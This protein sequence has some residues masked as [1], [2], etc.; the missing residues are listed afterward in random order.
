[1][2]PRMYAGRR[3]EAVQHCGGI[4]P[5]RLTKSS[6]VVIRYRTES[7]H[8]ADVLS[9]KGLTLTHSLSMHLVSF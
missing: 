6:C 3:V 4:R 5:L 7:G 8:P 9:L 1:M 2:Y